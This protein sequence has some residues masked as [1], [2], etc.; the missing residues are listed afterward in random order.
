MASLEQ[1]ICWPSPLH[2]LAGLQATQWLSV[3]AAVYTK[4]TFPGSTI[5]GCVGHTNCFS[6]FQ[7]EFPATIHK[8]NKQL[9]AMGLTL[10]GW[11]PFRLSPGSTRLSNAHR[12]LT[13]WKLFS[14]T[15]IRFSSAT[16]PI[17]PNI[18]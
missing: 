18:N 7:D 8:S 12:C 11:Q 2:W 16:F 5:S 3:G 13:T 10:P 14:K 15:T 17:V 9:R 4:N 1:A 6:V